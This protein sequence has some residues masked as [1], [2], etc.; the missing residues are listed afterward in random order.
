MVGWIIGL[1]IALFIVL[2]HSIKYITKARDW[3]LIG[4]AL[5]AREMDELSDGEYSRGPLAERIGRYKLW[6]VERL[7]SRGITQKLVILYTGE[8][9]PARFL[10]KD[11]KII[12]W[13]LNPISETYIP[14]VS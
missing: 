9:L 7:I 8:Y 4:K 12:G 3:E 10:V 5:G 2:V 14:P 6:H 11:G 13:A 1:A